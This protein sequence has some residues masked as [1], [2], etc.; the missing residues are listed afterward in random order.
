VTVQ[1]QGILKLQGGGSFNFRSVTLKSKSKLVFLAPNH[2]RISQAFT[3]DTASYVGPA[4]GST[5]DATAIIIYVAGTDATTSS[6]YTSTFG[7]EA[8]IYA[9]VYIPSGSLRLKD[10]TSATGA[11]IAY[12]V[13]L[14]KKTRSTLG[15]AFAGLTK[16]PGGW[17]QEPGTTTTESETPTV[18]ALDQNYPNPFNPSTTIR[19]QLPQDQKVT[20]EV[21]NVLGQR[22]TTLVNEAQ[23]AGTYLLQWD[24][25]N[26]QGYRVSSGVYF[27]RLQAGSF[28]E[29]R[30]MLL[31]R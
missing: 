5:F 28:V 29:S 18:F 13:L 24:A 21:Y 26:D 22:V 6:G 16:N 4:N 10:G 1:P 31:I 27:Y 2:V 7:P 15:T 25:T 12:N 14:G 11:F 9:N 30:K 3:G 8:N 23:A 19:Y 17:S 20:L